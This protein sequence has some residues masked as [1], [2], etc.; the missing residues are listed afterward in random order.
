MPISP[1]PFCNNLPDTRPISRQ[2]GSDRMSRLFGAEPFRRRPRTLHELAD[3]ARCVH[4]N[5]D[6][7]CRV[8]LP[9]VVHMP[10]SDRGMRLENAHKWC[11]VTSLRNGAILTL[12]TF[13]EAGHSLQDSGCVDL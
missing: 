10:N 6:F 11:V 2:G 7:M 8:H 12:K 1:L 13:A 4:N 5:E 9:A 3:L